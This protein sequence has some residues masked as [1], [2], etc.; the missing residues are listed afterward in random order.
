MAKLTARLFPVVAARFKVLAEPARLRILDALRGG[1]RSVGELG[2][3]TAL[4]QADL[5]KH[6]Q[7]LHRAGF[8]IRR[9]EGLFVYYQL[10]GREVFDLCDIMC[11]AIASRRRRR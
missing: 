5:S 4:S 7:L 6:L 8:V 2:A 3:Q 1:E 11:G 9:K 10:A